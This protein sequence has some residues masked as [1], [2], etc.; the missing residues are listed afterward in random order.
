M[1]VAIHDAHGKKILVISDE[2]VVGKKFVEGQ[3][4]LDL[5]GDFY[6]G[7][8]M[9]DTKI[10]QL[11]KGAYIIHLVGMQSVQLGIDEGFVDELNVRTVNG[12]PHA[13]VLV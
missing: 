13:E 8:L 4:Q 2:E 12:V 11:M 5:T 1:I 3:L 9:A 7:E 6:K 10:R